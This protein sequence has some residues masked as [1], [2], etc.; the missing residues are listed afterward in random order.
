MLA[1]A[2]VRALVI[3]GGLSVL[4]WICDTWPTC[5]FVTCR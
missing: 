4:M 3:C 5:D 1:N 2:A